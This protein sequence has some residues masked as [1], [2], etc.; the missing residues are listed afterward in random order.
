MKLRFFLWFLGLLFFAG[1]LKGQITTQT[2]APAK[3]YV[4]Q[5]V[6]FEGDTISYIPLKEVYVVKTKKFKSKKDERRYTRLVKYVKL[7][8]PYAKLAGQKLRQYDVQLRAEPNDRARRKI[9]K[10]AEDEL[11]A[12]YEGR[13]RSL[14]F[15]QGKILIKLLDRETNHS[16]Y[17][18]LKELRGTSSA[19]IWQGV[20][21]LFGYNLKVKY[22]PLGEDRQIEQIV[23]LI[24]MG[25]I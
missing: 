14:T 9:M 16:G 20:G 2:N 18:L 4:F 10:K 19:V 17:D 15:T 22:D 25:A 23:Q 7:V 12:E 6:I 24:E 13:L 21:R 11:R 1:T 8:Y 5:G 3:G